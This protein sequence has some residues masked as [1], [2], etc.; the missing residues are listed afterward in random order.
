MITLTANEICQACSGDLRAGAAAS[1]VESVSTDTRGDLT[2]CLFIA[3][4][5]E[6]FDGGD[7]A[8]EALASGAMGVLAERDA[9]ERLAVLVAGANGNTPVVIAV[10]D[11]GEALKDIAALVASRSG[12]TVVA[13]TGSTGKTSTKDILA[14]LLKGHV[15]VVSSRASFNN[16]VGVPLTLLDATQDTDVIVVEMGMQAQGEIAELCR[17]ASPEVAIITN[18]GPAHLQYAGSLENI[19]RGKAEIAQGLPPGGKL[20][21]PYGEKLLEPHLAG[22]DVE[23]VTFGFDEAAD[24]YPVFH[25]HM[26]DGRLHCVVSCCGRD[27]EFVFNFAAHHHL[28]NAM[29]AI[30][31]YYQ[32]GLP[33]ED[34]PEAVAG[35]NLSSL[36]GELIDLDNGV[37]LLNDCYNANPLSMRS[38]LEY[39]ASVGTGRRTV[40]VLG[41]MGELGPQALDYHRQVGRDVLELGIDC[42]IAVGEQSRGYLEGAAEDILYGEGA[43]EKDG[44]KY[45]ESFGDNYYFAERDEAL[46]GV[47]GLIRPGDV[48]LVK[49]S[50]FMRL[51]QLSNILIEAG[52]GDIPPDAAAKADGLPEVSPGDSPEG[53]PARED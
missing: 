17:I 49:A 33:L 5:G 7:F 15:D 6:N 28:Q 2:S 8:E 42:L 35:I 50:R 14:A 10:D 18:I 26:D 37:T 12:A 29:A 31:A 45:G 13:I 48:V 52:S 34:I 38:S 40:A 41:D 4:K 43:G 46:R 9:A 36:R 21:A 23:T 25:E 32:L 53:E 24:I 3:L 30:G 27:L 22:L 20:V 1:A 44:D 47:P 51:E 11:S 19:A 16:E 39:L